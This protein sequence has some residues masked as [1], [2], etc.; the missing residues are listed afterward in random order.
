M[1]VNGTNPYPHEGFQVE[2][3]LMLLKQ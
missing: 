2:S 1:D 3:P